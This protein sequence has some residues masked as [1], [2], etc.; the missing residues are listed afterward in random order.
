MDSGQR[1]DFVL[2]EFAMKLLQAAQL[3]VR[4]TAPIDQLSHRE[5]Q[6]MRAVEEGL[7]DREIGEKLDITEKT[8]KYYM[9]G[10]LQKYGVTNRVSAVIAAQK[11]R[12]VTPSLG[13]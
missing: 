11:L 3:N 10:I 12:G 1:T 7:T 4:Q 9:S 6:I 5:A 2:P 13:N 8:V